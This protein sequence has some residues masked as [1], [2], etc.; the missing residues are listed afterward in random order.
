[1][2]GSTNGIKQHFHI[3]ITGL[4]AELGQLL[5]KVIQRRKILGSGSGGEWQAPEPQTNKSEAVRWIKQAEYDYAALN[6]FLPN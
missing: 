5:G 3:A 2:D 1:M 4:E 6:G